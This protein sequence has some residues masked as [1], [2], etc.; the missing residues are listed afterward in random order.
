MMA[1]CSDNNSV[2]TYILHEAKNYQCFDINDS[3]AISINNVRTKIAAA[4]EI[5]S[6]PSHYTIE[7]ENDDKEYV[8]LNDYYLANKHPWKSFSNAQQSSSSTKIVR[9]RIVS[10]IEPQ[11]NIQP[12][13]K[14]TKPVLSICFF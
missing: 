2:S 10:S 3:T 5:S 12:G 7:I 14:I 11:S 4:M 1:S 13:E 6:L 9:L 8:V